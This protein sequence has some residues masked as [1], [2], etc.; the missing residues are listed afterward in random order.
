M[1]FLEGCELELL[2]YIL[3]GIR[4]CLQKTYGGRYL[5]QGVGWIKLLKYMSPLGFLLPSHNS[6]T[7]VKKAHFWLRLFR[8]PS[9]YV[10]LCLCW[11]MAERSPPVHMLGLALHIGQ[12]ESERHVQLGSG[13]SFSRESIRCVRRLTRNQSGWAHRPIVSN[14]ALCEFYSPS[15]HS[16]LFPRVSLQKT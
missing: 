14:Y 1:V 6:D 8:S 16:N 4:A 2:M 10:F 7:G 3:T 5:L 13:Y 15:L 9:C 12:S 11:P